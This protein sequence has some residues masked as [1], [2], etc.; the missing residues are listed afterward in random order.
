MR[1]NYIRSV[2]NT[3]SAMAARMHTS[4]SQLE[5]LVL[6][7]W[8]IRSKT[9]PSR[10]GKIC[11]RLLANRGGWVY[12]PKSSPAYSCSTTL[13]SHDG[14]TSCMGRIFTSLMQL[15][16]G[17]LHALSSRLTRWTKPLGTSLPLANPDRPWQKQVRAY[18][19]KCPLATATHHPQA[20]GE[21]A[22]MHEKRSLTPR[23][24]WQGW[25]EPGS[26]LSSSCNQ[27]PCSGGIGSSFACTGSASQRLLLTSRRSPRKRSP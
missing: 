22:R 24:A 18:R 21:T 7:T 27:I 11:L 5:R 10:R 14:E 13:F 26:R 25:F 12:N 8:I 4:R 2:E 19:R 6:A 15:K 1:G 20:A 23:P 17:C 3:K 16:D 9:S